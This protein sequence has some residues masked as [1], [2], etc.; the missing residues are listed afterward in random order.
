V[1]DRAPFRA[2]DLEELDRR[3][4]A[5]A[6]RVVAMAD[7]VAGARAPNVIGLRHD[8]DS[9]E[10]IET[11]AKMARW[12]AERGYRSTYYVLHTSPYW[13]SPAFPQLLE[14][15]AGYGHEIGIHSNA[16]AESLRT[17]EDPDEILDRAIARLRELGY[18]VRGVAGHGDPFCN[19]DRGI[20]EGTFAND[21][22]FLECRRVN[23]GPSDRVITR[24]AISR[25]IAPRPLADFG[26]EYDAVWCA[27]P[28][29]FRI[30]DSGGRWLNPGFG[31]TAAKFA[32]QLDVEELPTETDHP[33]QLHMLIHPDWWARA[34]AAER[35]AA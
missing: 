35:L 19:R 24:G 12:E 4:L 14:E 1:R 17:G 3:F 2:D 9:A 32:E 16:L 13:T 20:D 7:V 30:S 21:E 33:R 25:Q 23:M 22:Q 34:F 5:R 27:Y 15:I 28:F 26:L 10:S 31:E 11:A 18:P 8:C 29:P 6:A